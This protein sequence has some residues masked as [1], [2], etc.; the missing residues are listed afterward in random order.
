MSYDSIIEKFERF[1]DGMGLMTDEYAIPKRAIL[2]ALFGGVLITYIKPTL[3]FHH[4]QA[5]SWKLLNSNDESATM[6][7]WWSVPILTAFF[8]SF[9]V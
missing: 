5:R 2:G 4:G 3:M 7:P 1:F 9:M 8:T 6:I